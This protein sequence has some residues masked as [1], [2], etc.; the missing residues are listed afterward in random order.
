MPA[1]NVQEGTKRTPEFL[2]Q[3]DEAIDA[4]MM[5]DGQFKADVPIE[6]YTAS[7]RSLIALLDLKHGR[8]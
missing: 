3:L 6:I 8:K 1:Q 5:F 4:F 7:Q 2:K